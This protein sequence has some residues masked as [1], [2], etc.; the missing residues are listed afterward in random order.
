M[1]VVVMLAVRG[2]SSSGVNKTF[3]CVGD[4]VDVTVLI[5]EIYM[6]NIVLSAI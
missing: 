5:W 6:D 1:L 4:P 3:A 2:Q